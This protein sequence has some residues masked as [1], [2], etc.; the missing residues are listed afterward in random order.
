V[1]RGAVLLKRLGKGVKRGLRRLWLLT[2]SEASRPF[3]FGCS[4][5]LA[6]RLI[7]GASRMRWSTRQLVSYDRILLVIILKH[8][9]SA[10]G[11]Y[12]YSDILVRVQNY[13]LNTSGVGMD[14]ICLEMEHTRLNLCGTASI[15]HSDSKS[16]FSQ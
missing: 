5:H 8:F 11:N 9:F 3:T 12:L 15:Q 4:R 13:C 2:V 10:F 6:L 1:Q 7:L 14:W 16:S